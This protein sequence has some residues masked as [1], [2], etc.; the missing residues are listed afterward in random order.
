[1]DMIRKRFGRTAGFTLVELLVVIGIVALLVALLLPALRKA[2]NAEFCRSSAHG[3]RS[4]R[5]GADRDD[6]PRARPCCCQ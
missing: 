4:S 6:L 1:M 2:R 5:H 3:R